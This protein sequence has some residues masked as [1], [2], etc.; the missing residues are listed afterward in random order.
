MEILGLIFMAALAMLATIASAIATNI[1][2]DRVRIK[3]EERM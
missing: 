1:L 2:A 3:I